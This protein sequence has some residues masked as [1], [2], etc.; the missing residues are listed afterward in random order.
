M[1]SIMYFA[2]KGIVKTRLSLYEIT[3]RFHITSL[4]ADFQERRDRMP[5]SVHGDEWLI[6]WRLGDQYPQSK[7][8]FPY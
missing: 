7:F 4:F 8:G 6:S 1:G 3:V 2:A 5:R